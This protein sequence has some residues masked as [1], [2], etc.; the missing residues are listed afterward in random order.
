M[1]ISDTEIETI[2]S[3][4]KLD[5]QRIDVP[6]LSN[7]LNNILNFVQQMDAVDT[8]AVE[9]LASPVK[10]ENLLRK[11]ER[12]SAIDRDGFQAVAPATKDGLYLVPK[13]ID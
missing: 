12:D 5:L 2:A 11:D 6:R 7:D 8:T 13:V 10:T 9:P 1:K 3:L 4:A